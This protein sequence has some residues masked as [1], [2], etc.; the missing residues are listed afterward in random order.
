LEDF[1][2]ADR[3]SVDGGS[4]YGFA[5]GAGSLTQEVFG[6]DPGKVSISSVVRRPIEITV[7][8]HYILGYYALIDLNRDCSGCAI[9]ALTSVTM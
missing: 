3:L 9:S 4:G 7:T 2:V 5:F 6:T 8:V 1:K